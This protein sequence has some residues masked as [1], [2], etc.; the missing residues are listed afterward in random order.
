MTVCSFF[1]IL[2]L[3]PLAYS[4]FLS[5]MSYHDFWGSTSLECLSLHAEDIK[6]GVYQQQNSDLIWNISK[7]LSL[8][9]AYTENLLD[10]V[11][12]LHRILC[13]T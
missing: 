10:L 1:S 4:I 5:G 11:L 13:L 3:L 9:H 12:G 6:E 8:L 2:I 7:H